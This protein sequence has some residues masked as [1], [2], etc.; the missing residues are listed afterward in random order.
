MADVVV[1]KKGLLRKYGRMLLLTLLD[2]LINLFQQSLR[3]FW[4]ETARRCYALVTSR[5]LGFE[6]SLQVRYAGIDDQTFDR[7]A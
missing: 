2:G 1:R 3:W 4:S 5:I 6:Y 7:K